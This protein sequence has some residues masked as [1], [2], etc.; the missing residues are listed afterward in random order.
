[1]KTFLKI[2]GIIIVILVGGMAFAAMFNILVATGMM[3]ADTVQTGFGRELTQKAVMVWLG[4]V[5]LAGTSFFVNKW[6]RYILLLS[7]LYLP[8]GFAAIYVLM[9]Q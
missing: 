3:N 4:S 8:S 9:Q 1:M 2:A 6:W 5:V 7:P